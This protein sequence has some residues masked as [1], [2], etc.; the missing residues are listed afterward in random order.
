MLRS[1]NFDHLLDDHLFAGLPYFFADEPKIHRQ[2]VNELSR[3][4]HVPKEDICLVGSARIG[5]S[6][7][8]YKF[9][10]PFGQF[11]DLDIIVVSS[12]LFDSSWMDILTNRH[13]P[14]YSLLQVTRE[15]L[16]EHRERHHIYNGW[17]TPQFVAEALGIG[18]RWVTT[19]NGLSHIPSLSS[20]HI[21]SRLYRSWD[22]ARLYHRW[23]LRQLRNKLVSDQL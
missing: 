5:F 11:S 15:R 14:W 3:G 1:R 12:T 18:E 17:I 9:G 7:S 8:P 10:Q 23:S 22:H 13:T 2:M 6:L 4:L 21:S 19:F 16:Q 20:R